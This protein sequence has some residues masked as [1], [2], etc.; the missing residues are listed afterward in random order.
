M[1]DLLGERDE[2]EAML[3]GNE[4][5]GFCRYPEQLR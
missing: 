3:I 5:R 1:F 2:S 4:G